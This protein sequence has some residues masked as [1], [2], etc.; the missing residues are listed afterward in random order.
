[1]ASMGHRDWTKDA[2]SVSDADWA[3]KSISEGSGGSR[4]K[5]EQDLQ[6]FMFQAQVTN[7]IY[8]LNVSL[9]E[10]DYSA[11]CRIHGKTLNFAKC[12]MFYHIRK[13]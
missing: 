1:M 9:L 2:R 13:L 11:A 7:T 6:G 4:I 5:V 8:V 12:R 10:G 3:V